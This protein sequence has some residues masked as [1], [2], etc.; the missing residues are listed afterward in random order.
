MQALHDSYPSGGNYWSDYLGVDA[1]RGPLQNI[2]GVD[3]MGDTPYTN[4]GGM[5]A[6]QDPYPLM[7]P[8]VNGRVQRP[9]IRIDSNADFTPV[10]GV[11]GGDGSAGNPW[12]IENYDINGTGYG[13]CI[14]IGNTTDYFVVRD[15]YLHDSNGVT[16]WPFYYD[17][18]ITMYNASNGLL[19]GNEITRIRRGIYFYNGCMD[20]QVIGNNVSQA[21]EIGIHLSTHSDSNSVIGHMQ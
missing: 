10:N 19:S 5:W 17:T 1:M 2:P 14:Y 3:Y 6:P 7:L 18:G 11:S 21:S 4:I 16:I 9:P 13:Y 8:T 15:C 20:N 12:I